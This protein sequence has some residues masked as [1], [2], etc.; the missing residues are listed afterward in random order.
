LRA[1]SRKR[2]RVRDCSWRK[3]GEEEKE[4]EITNE[5]RRKRMW[6]G[7]SIRDSDCSSRKGKEE[8][9]RAGKKRRRTG[10]KRDEEKEMKR[11]RR[12]G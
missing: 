8:K 1:P 12:R 6:R 10:Y 2:R 4:G 7:R 9:E 11:R 3:R 5:R